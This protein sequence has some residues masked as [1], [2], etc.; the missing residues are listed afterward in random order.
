MGSFDGKFVSAK[1]D[2]T[3][4]KDFFT[5]LN[6]EFHFTVDLA[7]NEENALCADFFTAESDALTQEWV[8]T[9]WLNPPYG[10][11]GAN[12]LASWVKRSYEQAQKPGT[13]VVMLIPARTNTK[14]FHE[15]AMKAAELRFVCGRPKFGDAEHGLPQP[16]VLIV[17][18]KTDDPVEVSSFYLP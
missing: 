4:P 14:W 8:G 5:K 3:T 6:D 18:K 1:Q 7:A 12:S 13:T 10:A 17:F 9:C 15:Y 16:L 11:T 2:W